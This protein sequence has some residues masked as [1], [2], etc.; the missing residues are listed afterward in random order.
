MSKTM[1]QSNEIMIEPISIHSYKVFTQVPMAIDGC[2]QSFNLL[3][4]SPRDT[5]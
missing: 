5:P 2:N 3:T 1:V 4:I